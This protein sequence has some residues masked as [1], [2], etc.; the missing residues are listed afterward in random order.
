[1]TP[2]DDLRPGQYIALVRAK[3]DDAPVSPFDFFGP[4]KRSTDRID[5]RPLEILAISLPFLCVTDGRRRFGID[6][7]QYDVKRVTRQYA[8]HLWPE[9]RQ[10]VRQFKGKR[11]ERKEK[12]DGSYCQRCGSRLIQA[13]DIRNRVWRIACRDCGFDGGEVKPPGDL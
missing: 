6:L 3:D 8:E 9:R 1:M 11:R 4:P 5:G 13:Y 12:P 2:P 7:R 10:E